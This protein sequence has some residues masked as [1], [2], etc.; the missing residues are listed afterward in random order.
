MCPRTKVAIADAVWAR[1]RACQAA[2]L[3]VLAVP[4]EEDVARHGAT[5]GV[6]EVRALV[7]RW[8]IVDWR[9]LEQLL[10]P[11]RRSVRVLFIQL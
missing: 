2:L 10:H 5:V 1:E 9:A 6:V 3:I 11:V 4:H 7:Q 8:Q